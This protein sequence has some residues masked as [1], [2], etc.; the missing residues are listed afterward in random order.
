MAVAIILL[1]LGCLMA[2]LGSDQQKL[3][4][5][6][7]SKKITLTA[8]SVLLI[9]SW[10]LFCGFYSGITAALLILSLVMVMWLTIIFVQGHFS[11]KLLPFALYGSV[12]SA[13]LV[14][15]GGL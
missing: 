6:T 12:V 15:L 2:F 8:F 3:L 7:P 14:Q 4:T 10:L 1:W 13:A 5:T 9:I 11:I